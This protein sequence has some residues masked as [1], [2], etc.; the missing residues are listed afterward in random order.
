MAAITICSDFGAQ[1]NKVWHCFPIYFPWR[2]GTGC[3]MSPWTLQIGDLGT[4]GI[5]YSNYSYED[6]GPREMM[7]LVQLT[8]T[9]TEPGFR[10]LEFPQLSLSKF[11]YLAMLGLSCSM[12]DLVS[13]PGIEPRPPALGVWS[14][15]CW[16]T[17]EVPQF[18]LLTFLP[19]FSW[20]VLTLTSLAPAS[21]KNVTQLMFTCL[22]CAILRDKIPHGTHV[23]WTQ[24]RPY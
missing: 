21:Y 14:L 20:L 3:H 10:V 12:W 8:Q 13:W 22:S 24:I 7:W 2:D 19:Y 16:T 5:W 9:H 17:R 15:S 18:P 6:T 23:A 4:H 1:K 11:I